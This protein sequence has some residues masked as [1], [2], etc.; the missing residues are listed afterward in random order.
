MAGGGTRRF[1][2]ARDEGAP[3]FAARRQPSRTDRSARGP[4][5][6]SLVLPGTWPAARTWHTRCSTCLGVS[7]PL[8]GPTFRL[9]NSLPC[10]CRIARDADTQRLRL[11]YCPT[12][13]CAFEVLEALRTGVKALGELMKHVPAEGCDLDI[14]RTAET[15][16][17]SVIRKATAEV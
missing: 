3:T 13:G 8:P 5:G 16:G 12:H 17:R 14:A 6:R 15:M 2:S 4:P 9:D 10:G 1:L 7:K 11:W